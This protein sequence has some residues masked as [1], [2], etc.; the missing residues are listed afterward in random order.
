MVLK[1]KFYNIDF[2]KNINIADNNNDLILKIN[3]TLKNFPGL[4]ILNDEKLLEESINT[5]NNFSKNKKHFLVFGTGGS[6]LGA[7]AII[8]GLQKNNITID[9][10]DNIDPIRFQNKINNFDLTKIGFIIISKSGS[11]PETLSQYLSLIEIFDQKNMKDLLFNNSLIITEDK[12][13]PLTNIANNNNIHKINHSKDIGG[14]YSIFSNVGMIPAVI[15][16]LNVKNIYAGALEQINNTNSEDFIKIACFF[17]YQNIVKDLSSSVLMTYSDS[18]LYFG[19]WYLQLW[20]E[21]IGKDQKG[22]TPIHSVG[23][24]DQHSQLQLYLDGPRDKFFTFITTDHAD[25]G[26]KLN[27]EI[28]KENNIDYLFDKKMGDLMEAEQRATVDTF[29]QNKIPCRE[30]YLSTIDE[31]FMGKLLAFSIQETIATCLYFEVN[32]FNQPA[33]EQGKILTKKYLL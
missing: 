1:N 10:F 8:D 18:L 20:A 11:T 31:Y 19:K 13:S 2:N 32:P 3:Q 5:A 15:A 26:F 25:K 21:S 17:K 7:K 9:F 16:G 28:I 22:I 29:V 27:N 6:N 24:T 4:K 14:R 33:V 12:P 23:T 30:I